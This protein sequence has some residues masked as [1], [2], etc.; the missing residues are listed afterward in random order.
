MSDPFGG[1]LFPPL[2][3][4][5]FHITLDGRPVRTAEEAIEANLG[6]EEGANTGAGCGQDPEK[7]VEPPKGK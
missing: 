6:F 4:D 7:V 2:F 5:I 1:P 3:P